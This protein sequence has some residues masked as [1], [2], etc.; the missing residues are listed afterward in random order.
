M[1][2]HTHFMRPRDR[3]TDRDRQREKRQRRELAQNPNHVLYS[4]LSFHTFR[5]ITNFIW[6][7]LTIIKAKLRYRFKYGFAFFTWTL[8]IFADFATRIW[9][10]PVAILDVKKKNVSPWNDH[11]SQNWPFSAFYRHAL[12]WNNREPSRIFQWVSMSI[13]FDAL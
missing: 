8:E 12:V 9:W 1:Y 13:H 3:E 10:A 7:F 6:F 5:P 11:H 4:L 2:K